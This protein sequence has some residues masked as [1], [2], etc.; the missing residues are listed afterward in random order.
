[1]TRHLN[2]MGILR[3]LTLILLT[4]TIGGWG[5]LGQSAAETTSRDLMAEGHRHYKQGQT[6]Q[7]A[8]LWTQASANFQN[9]AITTA[10]SKL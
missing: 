3:T 5:L 9:L 1:M 10:Q 8:D 2:K 6:E 7:A 4:G